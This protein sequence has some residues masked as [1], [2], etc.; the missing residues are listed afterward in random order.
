LIEFLKEYS[1]K[2]DPNPQLF[3]SLSGK[4]SGS[5]GG[6]SN[7][8]AALLI[9]A[10]LRTQEKKDTSMN[11]ELPVS[12]SRRFNQLGFH[13]TR[14]YFVSKLA[15]ADVPKDVRKAMAGHSAD[16]AHSRYVHLDLSTQQRAL[17]KFEINP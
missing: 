1:A 6:L 10:G 16:S 4:K 17:G 9:K 12:K 14:H 3:P 7:Q 5:A 13:S 2:S 8:F 11:P 15:N